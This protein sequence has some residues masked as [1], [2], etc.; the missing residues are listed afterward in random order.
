MSRRHRQQSTGP[1]LFPPA[2]LFPS[3]QPAKLLLPDR[4]PSWQQKA[5]LNPFRIHWHTETHI[6]SPV[7]A[8]RECARNSRVRISSEGT[9]A[10][11]SE[12]LRAEQSPYVP[13]R[14][15]K[16]GGGCHPK[17]VPPL[18]NRFPELRPPDCLRPNQL[19][20]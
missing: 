3:T 14:T 18:L 1:A 13:L 20:G 11:R 6:R 15:R 9:A 7:R 4:L 17:K 8:P 16:H 10:V 2:N 12:V 5:R 19:R